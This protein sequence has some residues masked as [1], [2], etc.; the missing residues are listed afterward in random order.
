M[1]V[2]PPPSACFGAPDGIAFDAQDNLYIADAAFNAVRKITAS[3]IISTVAGTGTAGFS[4]DGGL[5]TSAALSS[6][7]GVAADTQGNL[8]IADSFNKRVRKVSATGI[9]TTVVGGG[10]VNQQTKAGT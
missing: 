9:I 7:N 10:G 3:G 8:Y 6:P 2:L 5:A 1:A 4:G